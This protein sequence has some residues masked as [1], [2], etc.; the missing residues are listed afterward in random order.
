VDV[1]EGVLD[2][3]LVEDEAPAVVEVGVLV[4]VL[5]TLLVEDVLWALV[6]VALE[7]IEVLVSVLLDPR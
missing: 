6:D 4:G 2:A 3:L 5:D 7:A 1:L